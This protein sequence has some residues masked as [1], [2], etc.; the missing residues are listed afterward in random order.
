[1]YEIILTAIFLVAYNLLPQTP[2][3][4]LSILAI[5][6][7][8]VTPGL[9]TY[10]KGPPFVPSSDKTIQNAIQLAKLKPTDTVVDLGCGNAKFLIAAS[11]YCQKA[12]GYELSFPTYLMAKFKTRKY[13]NIKIHYKNFW[14]EDHSKSD[15]VFCFLLLRLMPKVYEEIWPQLKPGSRLISNTFSMKSL[16]PS[17]KIDSTILYIK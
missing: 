6:L 13:S 17:Q 1:M 10:I 15:V 5:Y 16:K 8:L 7:G 14:K 12:I 11:P 3:Y 9:W 4:Q 2:V